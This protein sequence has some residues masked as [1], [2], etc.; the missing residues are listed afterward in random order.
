MSERKLF[1]VIG[2]PILHSRSPDLFRAAF[3]DMG[4]DADY[5]RIAADTA[6]E[7]VEI[8]RGIGVSGFNVTAPY[9]EDVLE[10]VDSR[11][12]A[13]GH[14]GAANTIVVSDGR[15]RACNTDWIGVLDALRHN[16]CDPSGKKVVILGAGG[17]GRAAAWGFLQHGSREVIIANRGIGRARAVAGSLG[18]LACSLDDAGAALEGADILV[19]C[20]P[21]GVTSIRPEWI[22]RKLCVLEANYAQP[23]LLEIARSAGCR[24]IGGLEWLVWQALAGLNLFTQRETEKSVMEKGLLASRDWK[25]IALIG[26]MGT[27]KSTIGKLLADSLNMRFVDCDEEV[28]QCCGRKISEFFAE[29]GD[30]GAHFRRIEK[31]VVTQAASGEG[32]V[33]ALGGGALLDQENLEAIRRRS[34]AVWLWASLPTALAR[35]NDGDRPLLNGNVTPGGPEKL[36]AAR[37][38]G[39]AAAADLVV[40][41]ES[42]SPADARRKIENEIRQAIQG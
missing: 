36:W 12:H 30:D 25:N 18:C 8:A 3:S 20:L 39:Y 37:R 15:L 27:G 11:D 13:T 14:I 31:T 17:A 10:Y 5:T 7:A 32:A 19:S 26:F 6:S 28:E 38:P 22:R 41:T 40:G 4:F 9:K 16:G 24:V 35:A 42:G 21:A 23:L 2:R 33:L 34:L 1:A 29:H